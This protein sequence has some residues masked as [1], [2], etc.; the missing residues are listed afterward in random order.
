MAE[1]KCYHQI[2]MGIFGK[3][4][5]NAH[6]GCH[7]GL[8]VASK[9]K[10]GNKS[11]YSITEIATLIR[12]SALERKDLRELLTQPNNLFTFNQNAKEP[13]LFDNL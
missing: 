1:A 11:P 8:S 13:N 6:L 7:F 9:D 10:G 12:V 2:I 3:R 5:Q 4:S